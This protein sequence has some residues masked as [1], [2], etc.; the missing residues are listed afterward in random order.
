MLAYLH[1]VLK[2]SEHPSGPSPGATTSGH[3]SMR[4]WSLMSFRLR[5]RTHISAFSMAKVAHPM[6]P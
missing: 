5:Q 3:F 1:R 4:H 6:H 2:H